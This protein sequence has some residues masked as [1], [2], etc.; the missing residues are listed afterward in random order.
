MTRRRPFKVSFSSTRQES[1]KPR[2]PLPRELRENQDGRRRWSRPFSLLMATALLMG[3]TPIG[4]TGG[5]IRAPIRSSAPTHPQTGEKVQSAGPQQ[6]L[7]PL[8]DEV[9][10]S[11]ELD[12]RL[13]SVMAALNAAGYD[14]ENGARP[15]S[16]LR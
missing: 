2:D 15:L 11:V 14:Y 7:L 9:N 10:V 12:P 3:L 13:F 1:S 4:A 5:L 8:L 16:P 6:D